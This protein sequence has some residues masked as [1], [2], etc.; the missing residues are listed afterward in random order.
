MLFVL[1]AST[2]LAWSLE[3]GGGMVDTYLV[4]KINAFLSH[5]FFARF[6]KE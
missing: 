6:C 5:I 3:F 4:I 2:G 1:M